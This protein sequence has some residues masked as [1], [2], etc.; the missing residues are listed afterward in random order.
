MYNYLITMLNGV[1]DIK[2]VYAD[3]Q[4]PEAHFM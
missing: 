3:E 2:H 1:W 4:E